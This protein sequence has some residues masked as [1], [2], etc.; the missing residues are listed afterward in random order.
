[1]RADEAKQRGGWGRGANR[2]RR[3][4]TRPEWF[5]LLWSESARFLPDWK[6]FL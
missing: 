5:P 3:S 4:K 1:V 6:E 2:R